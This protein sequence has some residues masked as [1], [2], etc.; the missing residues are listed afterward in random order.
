MSFIT[1]PL[2]IKRMLT[3]VGLYSTGLWKHKNE[4]VFI[5]FFKLQN[6]APFLYFTIKKM[7]YSNDTCQIIQVLGYLR[8]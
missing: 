3:H 6:L 2:S 4:F 8:S 7:S 1:L 5:H